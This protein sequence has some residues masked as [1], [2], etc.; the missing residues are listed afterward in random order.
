MQIICISR[1]SYGYGKDLAE[2]LADKLGYQSIAREELV[3]KATASGIPVG[4]L[5]TA[6]VKRQLFSEELGIEIDRF[7]AFMTHS[8][9]EQALKGGIVYHGRGGHLVLPGLIHV[10]RI[11]AIA[12][13]E[14]RIRMVMQRMNFTRKQAKR[15][16]EEVDEDR[17][18]Y[19][20]FLYNVDCDDPS[21][22]DIVINAAHLA[23]DNSASALIHMAQLPEFQLTPALNQ[24]IHDLL[25][26]SKC[27]LAIYEDERTRGVKVTVSAEKGNVSVTYIPRHG[28][29]A[30]SIPSIIERI[31]GVK[32]LICTVASTNIFYIQEQFN[33]EVPSFK[34][35]VEI[36]AKWNA[37]VELIRL[38]Q[39]DVKQ[40]SNEL[41][42]SE[43]TTS[44]ELG[45]ILDDSPV[46]V[47]KEGGYG[48][49]E[50]FNKLIQAGRA[51]ACNTIHG[52][53][54]SLANKIKQEKNYSLVVVGDVF[55]SHN[56]IIRKR[57]K[58]DMISL[59]SDQASSPVISTDELEEQY[60]FRPR[61]WINT[62]IYA[63]LSSLL[64]IFVFTN[65]KMILEFLSESEDWY[66][67]LAVVAV[68]L[69]APLAAYFIGQFSHNIMKFL[70]VE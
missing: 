20:R 45:G 35:L 37:S 63:L 46:T 47:K 15:Y 52:G 4:K 54:K 3:D 48:I 22:Y 13:L 56:S 65:Q 5:E 40:E 21:H 39:D 11:R 12:N 41:I 10:L 14:D 29:K 58:R 43:L 17:R 27:R 38:V 53:M 50:T 42:S 61:Q 1:F 25:L 44:R 34:H 2:R 49:P 68:T 30:E 7:K 64:L 28:K 16:I 70:K 57:L 6:I 69:F 62:I 24:K 67:I 26:E 9:C 18:K 66:R 51:G 59:L 8:L 36:A 23:V 19:S 32:S 60:L 55:L 33:P 31:Q